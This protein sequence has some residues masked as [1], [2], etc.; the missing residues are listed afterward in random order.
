MLT[1]TA[2]LQILKKK[3]KKEEEVKLKEQRRREREEAKKRREEEQKQKAEERARKA[4]FKAEEKAQREEEKVHKA[5]EK[6]LKADAKGKEPVRGGTKRTRDSDRSSRAKFPQNNLPRVDM[7]NID[8]IE[9]CICFELYSRDQPG[10]HCIA[11]ACGRWLHEDCAKDC[12]RQERRRAYLPYLFYF[13]QIDV[14]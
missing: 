6:L 13:L 3:R 10:M 7:D 2:A 5:E 8:Q 1:S 11:C 12:L 4:K 14:L 9:C